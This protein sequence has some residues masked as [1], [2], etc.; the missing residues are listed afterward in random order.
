VVAGGGELLAG[1]AEAAVA[2]PWAE[3]GAEV[4]PEE[5][6]LSSATTTTA[7]SSLVTRPI[8]SIFGFLLESPSVTEVSVTEVSRPASAGTS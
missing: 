8:A 1:A 2:A 7:A 4:A 6:P 3:A 5:H